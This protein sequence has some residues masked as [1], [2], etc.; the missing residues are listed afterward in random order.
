MGRLAWQSKNSSMSLT[1]PNTITHV[2]SVRQVIAAGIESR[3]SSP[4]TAADGRCLRRISR[5]PLPLAHWRSAC[6]TRQMYLYMTPASLAQTPAKKKKKWSGR[7]SGFW[8]FFAVKSKLNGIGAVSDIP[9]GVEWRFSTGKAESA[10]CSNFTK[11][12]VPTTH[13]PSRK[14]ISCG[15][16]GRQTVGGK[17][18]WM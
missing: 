1:S 16:F 9:G 18:V 17:P 8:F 2:P 6:V 13:M 11:V 12:Y 5:D 3:H 7:T 15:L 14:S 4:L 10:S